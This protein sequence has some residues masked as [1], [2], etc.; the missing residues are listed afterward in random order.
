ML[1]YLVK[2]QALYKDRQTELDLFLPELSYDRST[3]SKLLDAVHN[4]TLPLQTAVPSGVQR[5]TRAEGTKIGEIYIPG[6]H[7]SI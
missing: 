7:H 2:D 3:N 1:F 6:N 5:M 4:E